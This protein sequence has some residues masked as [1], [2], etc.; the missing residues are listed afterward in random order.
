MI[1][2]ELLENYETLVQ[3]AEFAFRDIAERCKEQVT[4]KVQCADCCHSFFGL[5]PI[6]AAYISHQF[7]KLDRRVRKEVLE[8][9][10]QA[11]QKLIDLDKE[12]QEKFGDDEEKK[13]KEAAKLRVRCPLLSDEDK[14]LLYQYRPITCRVYGMPA[15]TGGKL[16]VCWKAKFVKGDQFPSFNL[17]L[18]YREL[19]GLS[20]QFLVSLGRSGEEAAEGGGLL[21]SLAKAISTPP[22]ELF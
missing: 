9:A 13:L 22:E 12:L 15:I 6:E 3:E 14:C 8:R 5:F 11:E 7:P 2:K 18:M 16:H 4:C 21:I 19:Y 10:A 20:K 17:D 1:N